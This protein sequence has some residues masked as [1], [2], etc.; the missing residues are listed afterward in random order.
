MVPEADSAIDCVNNQTFNRLNLV[1]ED[2][3][4]EKFWAA[5]R[6]WS[7]LIVPYL[8]R[9]VARVRLVPVVV[10]RSI[11]NIEDAG[12]RTALSTRSTGESIR[13]VGCYGGID[14]GM[15]HSR[16]N[17]GIVPSTVAE[18]DVSTV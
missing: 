11:L 7:S 5:N 13:N 6:A 18:G 10:E 17:V 3:A 4:L 8:L 16:R 15:L 14:I 1:V 9:L 2:H 12:Q